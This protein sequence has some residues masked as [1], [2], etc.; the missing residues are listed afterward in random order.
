M[1]APAYLSACGIGIGFAAAALDAAGDIIWQCDLTARAHDIVAD[2]ARD[3]CVVMGRK[4]GRGAMICRLSDGESLLNLAPLPGHSFDGHAVFSADGAEI[5]ATQSD[6]R[7][8]A[9]LI[10]VYET[11]TG[12]ARRH[13]SSHGIE[14]HELIW[15]A[16]GLLVI[17][18]GGIRDRRSAD[19]IESSLALIAAA[20]GS[21]QRHWILDDEWETLSIRHIAALA[22]GRFA[23]AMQDQDAAT[24]RRPLVAIAD[25][26]GDLNFLDIPATI[27]RRLDGY[28]GSVAVD[29]GGGIIAATAPRGGLALFW[30]AS[31][32]H[33]LGDIPLADVCGVAA[34]AVS[35]GFC[36]TSGHGAWRN[37]HMS[38]DKPA[39]ASG[40]ADLTLQWD[41]HLSRVTG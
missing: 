38:A 26:V 21:L 5:F 28:I 33:Y 12:I 41:N 32:G 9:G 16:P 39:F 29:A 13:F 24:D 19:A 14:P 11:A 30:S 34:D 6:D 2:P 22:D 17:G 20:D 3:I 25:P 10:V 8:Q 1:T 37:V 40:G 31:D 4:P 18:N 36:L 23:F 7:T 15:A 27:Q 35:G